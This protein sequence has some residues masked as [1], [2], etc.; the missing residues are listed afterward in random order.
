[1]EYVSQDS[2]FDQGEADRWFQRNRDAILSRDLTADD[3]PMLLL[4]ASGLRP[5]NCLEVGAS[6][7]FRLEAIRQRLGCRVTA[8]EPSEEAIRDGR[9]RF[10]Q[11]RFVR[12]LAHDLTGLADGEFD[13]VVVSFVLH[14][15]DRAWLLRTVAELDRV[16]ADGGH[17]LLADFDPGGPQRVAYHHL[18][19]QDVWTYKQDY[20]ALWQASCLYRTVERR[21]FDHRSH[22]FG[23]SIPPE[24]HC[25]AAMLRK[26]ARGIYQEAR[27]P[28]S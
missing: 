26:D 23:E 18:P 12:G 1:M 15:V 20:P 8:V 10:S 11:V 21:A 5:T 3:P 6:N 9:E 14:W 25:V 2:L 19:G 22:R 13:L 7:G 24:H 4:L 28:G 16:L 27:L 17:V